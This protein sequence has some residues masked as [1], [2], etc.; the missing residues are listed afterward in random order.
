[1]AKIHNLNGSIFHIRKSKRY[2]WLRGC[3]RNAYDTSDTWGLDNKKFEFDP[4][5]KLF[6][7]F[8]LN[9]HPWS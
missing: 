6:S 1:M 5:L 3:A 8:Y 9:K 4:Y 2:L 7:D